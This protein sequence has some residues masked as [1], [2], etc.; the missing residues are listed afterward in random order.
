MAGPAIDG[1]G[2]GSTIRD[3]GFQPADSGRIGPAGGGRD[4]GSGLSARPPMDGSD[5]TVDSDWLGSDDYGYGSGD[6]TEEWEAAAAWQDDVLDYVE[7][8]FMAWVHRKGL[9]PASWVEWYK[10]MRGDML[11]YT[12][13]EWYLPYYHT[14]DLPNGFENTQYGRESLGR[15]AFSWLQNQ[16]PTQ[17]ISPS[18]AMSYTAPPP[19]GPG[20]G[21]GGGR[22]G[23][24]MADFDIDEL[25]EGVQNMW[26]AYLL[27]D[28]D[29]ARDIATAY[30]GAVIANP[31]QKL[32]FTTYV[33]NK[34]RATSRHKAIY[35]N[36]PDHL[37]ERE[38]MTRYLQTASQ[39][40]RPDN[41]DKIAIGGAQLGA[42]PTAFRGLIS[43][44][45][46]VRNSA[47]WINNF[48]NRISEL[49]GLFRG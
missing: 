32:D 25:T 35:A 27:T 42:D 4:G 16:D 17:S 38:F 14:Q 47:P 44:Q 30:A 40:L 37:E 34:I 26:R 46:E 20:G 48:E 15:A 1:I 28:N 11:A 36:K 29:N 49:K 33:L 5:P 23:P 41:A 13:N 39:Y 22:R 7:E 2:S 12:Y 9:D 6:D 45:R 8:Q 10:S 31:D 43:N 24:S 18:S 3:T 19:R 21:R